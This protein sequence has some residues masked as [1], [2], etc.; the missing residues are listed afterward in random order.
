MTNVFMMKTDVKME[1][2]YYMAEEES[3]DPLMLDDCEAEQVHIGIEEGAVHT[4]LAT[5]IYKNPFAGFRELYANAIRACKEA[6]KKYG[7]DPWIEIIIDPVKLNFTMI[8]HDSIGITDYTF[9]NVL[10]VL[11]R[12]SNFD[13]EL[14]GQF[15]IGM[16]A[17]YALTDIMFIQS[18]ARNGDE[19]SYIMRNMKTCDN[20][21]KKNPVTI[22]G[23][24]T[25]INLKMQKIKQPKS[26]ADISHSNYIRLDPAIE[27]LEEIA[28]FSG[29]RTELTITDNVQEDWGGDRG[30]IT[31]GPV[32]TTEFFNLRECDKSNL[33]K[34]S[35]DDYDLTAFC[36]DISNDA[37][38]D[39][40]KK[41]T[42]A[43]M[44]IEGASLVEL[45]GFER[46]HV[47]IKNE[48][49]YRPV[50]SRDALMDES[51]EK[52]NQKIQLDL[53]EHLSAN[54]ANATSIEAWQKLSKMERLHIHN[55][56]ISINE[57]NITPEITPLMKFS[58]LMKS[59]C[60][61]YAKGRTSLMHESM[62]RALFNIKDDGIKNVCC[63]KRKNASKISAL[64][65]YHII[66]PG[67]EHFDLLK[68]Y[69]VDADDIKID[70]KLIRIYNPSN[71]PDADIIQESELDPE[72]DIRVPESAAIHA[73]NMRD[74]G[75]LE[76]RF[77]R[78]RRGGISIDEFCDKIL[79]K[80]YDGVSGREIIKGKYVLVP[81][82]VQLI[83]NLKQN[84]LN[85]S[86]VRVSKEDTRK[87]QAVCVMNDINMPTKYSEKRIYKILSK[88]YGGVDFSEHNGV[89]L[90][91]DSLEYI[92][93]SNIHIRDCVAKF[94]QKGCTYIDEYQVS[95]IVADMKRYFD[96][97]KNEKTTYGKLLH[98]ALNV[99]MHDEDA[100][101]IWKRLLKGDDH[102]LATARTI[103]K[104]L[105]GSN[106]I[107]VD[108]N[109]AKGDGIDLILN[110]DYSTACDYEETYMLRY[111]IK[112]Q[113]LN[114]CNKAMN[115]LF[116]LGVLNKICQITS[117]MHNGK[118]TNTIY[119]S[120]N[121]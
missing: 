32:E 6:E 73:Y 91:I 10:T 121:R 60:R 81:T 74:K 103:T 66:I 62:Q 56:F 72:T 36:Y 26:K 4:I 54:Y 34:I 27:Y 83:D 48:R 113:M 116:K 84:S 9:K 25:K 119:I 29:I 38:H 43:G 102:T 35:N 70:K 61:I 14:P 108:I 97:A 117:T 19:N 98:L 69:F 110:N 78:G 3:I 64:S 37:H 30:T 89:E 93:K 65:D 52:L 20:I 21:I 92:G 50:A 105:G 28:M 12:S 80:K 76:Y 106:G 57:E 46:Y 18:R 1:E 8:E 67:Q 107:W 118:I 47:N 101:Q 44:P 58:K 87:I 59:E 82:G 41:I 109:E 79:D 7:A 95:E 68:K 15:G 104:A 85:M 55:V 5:Q 88:Q 22:D 2:S 77:F 49:T 33:F 75:I 99:S 42:V 39:Y 94:Y 24:G 90:M 11:G 40:Y 120:S 31:I 111:T 114:V 112:G 100:S 13:G 16:A 96:E 17:Y 45:R 51:L 53:V 86:H 71:F 23:Y 63:M 115:K